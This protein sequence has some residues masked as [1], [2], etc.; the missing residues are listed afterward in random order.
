MTGFHPRAGAIGTDPRRE[1][2]PPFPSHDRCGGRSSRCPSIHSKEKNET[3]QDRMPEPG[4]PPHRPARASLHRRSCKGSRRV[5]VASA[6]PSSK[7]KRCAIATHTWQGRRSHQRK[8]KNGASV[9][10]GGRQHTPPPLFNHPVGIA[11]SQPT[12]GVG[13]REGGSYQPPHAQGINTSAA[14]R[15]A[16]GCSRPA[17]RRQQLLG[18]RAQHSTAHSPTWHDRIG[19]GT[20]GKP[21]E[22][23]PLGEKHQTRECTAYLLRVS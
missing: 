8:P 13:T 15:V 7:D 17:R 3:T 18:M 21:T 5:R 23:A 19:T 16:P 9:Q 14:S 12:L 1:P 4:V 2:V 20:G 6:P 22:T 11:S 10:R